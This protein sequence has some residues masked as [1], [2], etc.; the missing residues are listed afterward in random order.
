MSVTYSG[1]PGHGVAPFR[2]FLQE[3]AALKQRLDRAIDRVCA[4]DGDP[5][6][7]TSM[8]ERRC[9]AETRERTRPAVEVAM[10]RGDTRLASAAIG[11]GASAR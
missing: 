6:L 1:R 5:S 9:V 2:G 4:M 3:R 10:R 8:A 7:S 11:V